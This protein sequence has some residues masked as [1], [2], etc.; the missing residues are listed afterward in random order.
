M[1]GVTATRVR[2][3][4]AEGSLYAKRLSGGWQFPAMQF[5][6]G[7]EL[8]GWSTVAKAIPQSAPLVA[9]DA[10]LH[11]PAIQLEYAGTAR[12]PLDW[13]ASGGDAELAAQAVHDALTRLP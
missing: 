3:R 9:V 8:P 12:S 5:P 1:L 7:R 2:Q 4:A 11:G 6:G 10:A 13:L